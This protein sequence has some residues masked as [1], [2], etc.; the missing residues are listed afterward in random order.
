MGSAVSFWNVATKSGIGRANFQ[1]DPHLL[2]RRL[3]HHGYAVTGVLAAE[4]GLPP[5][6]HRDPF[7]RIL[8]AQARVE[9]IFLLTTDR[10]LACYPSP[11][12]AL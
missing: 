3:L 12:R 4:A 6:L 9:R 8:I 5:M 7:D 11:I 1:V 2:H 10:T